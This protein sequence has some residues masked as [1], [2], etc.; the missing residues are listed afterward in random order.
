MTAIVPPRRLHRLMPAVILAATATLGSLGYPAIAGAEP[1][2]DID[3]Y[4]KCIEDMYD[5]KN[6]NL[7]T[8]AKFCCALS[9]GVWGPASD[10]GGPTCTA[11]ALN[12]ESPQGP[13][14][15]SS[16]PRPPVTQQRPDS[17]NPS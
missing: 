17:A 12:P 2:W 9:G 4:D 3:Q 16:P 11:P 13:G 1:V 7:T 8:V 5:Y 6:D 15:S 10:G 14:T